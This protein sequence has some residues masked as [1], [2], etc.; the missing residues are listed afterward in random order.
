[1]PLRTEDIAYEADGREL[2]GH[3]ALD[4]DI[5]RPRPGVLICHEG[6][7]L[8][9]H[10]RE[11]AQR[12]AADGYVAFALDYHGGGRQLPFDS[13]MDRLGPL[14][15]DSPRTRELGRA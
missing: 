7:G 14:I 15:A 4:D 9:D 12:L 10:M 8:D 11:R 5:D 2:I 6:P 1:M 13:F 3:L